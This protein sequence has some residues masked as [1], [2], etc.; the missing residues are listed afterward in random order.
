MRTDNINQTYEYVTNTDTIANA[1]SPV[2][3]L[4]IPAGRVYQIKDGTPLILKMYDASGNELPSSANVWLAWQGPVGKTT[5]Q[6][7]RTMNYGIFAR[8]TAADQEDIN[9]Q[10]RR[11]IRFDSDE[12]ARAQ[13]GEESIITGLTADYKIILMV[14]STVAVDV[15]QVDYQFNFDAVVLTQQEFLS[16][17]T[18]QKNT[19]VQG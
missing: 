4:D 2:A 10:G 16:L 8:I 15:T 14:E 13:R 3:T 12:V 6:A 5:Y 9:T 17:K 11:L 18:G 7:G 1:A 19:L